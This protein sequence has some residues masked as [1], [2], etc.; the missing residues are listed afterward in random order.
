VLHIFS[1]VFFS[2]L[3]VSKIFSKFINDFIFRLNKE[4][5]LCSEGFQ[6]VEL[7][8]E[9]FG[10]FLMH[11]KKINQLFCLHQIEAT[12]FCKP[13]ERPCQA[14]FESYTFLVLY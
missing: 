7:S 6:K 8:N 13:D 10:P 4:P 2:I 3:T 12:L 14:I 9:I 1:V 5:K 11:A